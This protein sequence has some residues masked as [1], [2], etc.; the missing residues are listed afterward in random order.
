MARKPRTPKAAPATPAVD[1]PA[2]S[3]PEEEAWT[4]PV[5][6]ARP[7]ASTIRSVLNPL[8]DPD[9]RPAVPPS[10]PGAPG[11]SPGPAPAA[12]APGPPPAASRSRHKA[13][14]PPPVSP[15]APDILLPPALPASPPPEPPTTEE[16]FQR[17]LAAI[18]M[19]Q[20]QA[21]YATPL[22]IIRARMLFPGEIPEASF[23]AA[24]AAAPFIHPRLSAIAMAGAPSG[25]PEAVTAQQ[26]A[27]EAAHGHMRELERR[28]RAKGRTIDHMEVPDTRTTTNGSGNGKVH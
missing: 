5:P 16:V 18:R 25:P 7:E 22:D 12:S 28:L 20:E 13:P 23:Q 2:V 11:W 19:V 1:P 9:A 14:A 4:P 24:C 15:P 8:M 6:P 10:P 26:R 21:P 3:A 17:I 27:L